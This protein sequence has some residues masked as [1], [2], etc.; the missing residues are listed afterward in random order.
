VRAAA[1]ALRSGCCDCRMV[2]LPE[3]AMLPQMRLRL[4]CSLVSAYSMRTLLQ[5]QS[6][7]SATSCA[8]EVMLPCP[9]SEQA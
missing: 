9:I 8:A 7:S 3:E 2:R 1:P 4:M 6:S 5:S